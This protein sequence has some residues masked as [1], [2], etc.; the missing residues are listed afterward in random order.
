[1]SLYEQLVRSHYWAWVHELATRPTLC[2]SD[3]G[4]TNTIMTGPETM[5]VIDLD[6]VTYDLP[7]RDLRKVFES[8][9][10]PG[11]DLTAALRRII[12]TYTDFCP[13]PEEKLAVFL[14]DVQFPYKV[15]QNAKYAF[16]YNILETTELIEEAQLDLARADA[17]R[18]LTGSAS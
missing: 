9:L 14:I 16:R 10:D 17:V 11:I 7:I 18:G 12:D 15:Y 3:Y 4:E 2:H 6:T 5:W 1:E 13:L 8:Y